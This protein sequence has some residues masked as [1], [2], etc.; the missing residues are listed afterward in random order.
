M[1]VH[2]LY[3]DCHYS[4]M[5]YTWDV[6][7]CGPHPP[8][9]T[10]RALPRLLLIETVRHDRKVLELYGANASVNFPHAGIVDPAAMRVQRLRTGGGQELPGVM[11]S[12]GVDKMK[13]R[14]ALRFVRCVLVCRALCVFE[15]SCYCGTRGEV[16]HLS[17]LNAPTCI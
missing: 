4:T 8:C 17:S 15:R 1:I 12:V 3:R 2:I 6:F 11:S 10:C 5:P 9:R 16:T 7:L 14:V 13:V